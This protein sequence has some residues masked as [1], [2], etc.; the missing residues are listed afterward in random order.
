MIS[1][2][3]FK[4]GMT[5][6]LDDTL[7]NIVFFQHVKPGKGAA[8]VRTKLKNLKTGAV[9]EKTFRAGEKVELAI[10]DKRRMQFLYREGDSLH[11]MDVDS[12]EQM[13]L[14]ADEV[15]D[16]ALWLKESDIAEVAM[17][18]GKPVSV[19]PPMVVELEVV[20]TSP[21]V[22][23]DTASGGTKPATLETGAVVQVPLF[24]DI[25]TVIKVDSRSG[26]YLERVR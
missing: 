18:E 19:E 17:Y 15:G 10:L 14:P 11:L 23:G 4:N 22:K 5:I 1:T 25:G 7:F 13:A 20:E 8:F 9:I 24:V 6:E 12:Y 2:S 3:E 21:G 26:K 16:I